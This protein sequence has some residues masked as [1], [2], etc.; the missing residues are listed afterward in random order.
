MSHVPGGLIAKRYLNAIRPG[1]GVGVGFTGYIATTEIP[2]GIVQGDAATE[3]ALFEA[4]LS[5]AQTTEDFE[6][7]AAADPMWSVPMV[8]NGITMLIPKPDLVNYNGPL[9]MLIN[10]TDLNGRFNTTPAGVN[11]LNTI[12]SYSTGSGVAPMTFY[13]TPSIAFFGAYF[14]D[15]GDFV[16]DWNFVFVADDNSMQT[17]TYSPPGTHMGT[18]T[19]VGFVDDSKLYK[20]LIIYCAANT[21]PPGVN[22]CGMDDATYG[23]ASFLI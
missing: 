2:G 16:G 15:C 21:T 20:A 3:R 1:V 7:Y 8:Q 13:F 19:F 5:G 18:L 10:D 6:S 12:P 14:T 9:L 11:Y 17:L 23:P 4:R 22:A